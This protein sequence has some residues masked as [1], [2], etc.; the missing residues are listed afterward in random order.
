MILSNHFGLFP[1]VTRWHAVWI[2][3]ISIKPIFIIFRAPFFCMQWSVFFIYFGRRLGSTR[4]L[5]LHKWPP[6][7]PL[8]SSSDFARHLRLMKISFQAFHMMMFYETAFGLYQHHPIYCPSG[9]CVTISHASGQNE[10]TEIY[11]GLKYNGD[12]HAMRASPEP[13][14]VHWR[15]VRIYWKKTAS[16]EGSLDLT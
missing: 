1:F 4:I 7:G 2:E 14:S 11:L 13:Q 15:V 10:P 16:I 12:K 9:R 3:G 5:F 6:I 8:L